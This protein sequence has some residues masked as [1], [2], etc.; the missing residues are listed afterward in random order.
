MAF[1]TGTQNKTSSAPVNKTNA[2]PD[3]KRPL[4]DTPKSGML[5]NRRLDLPKQKR[6][7]N[8]GRRP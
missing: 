7:G 2:D 6:T 8:T 4:R 1:N 3:W 5:Q